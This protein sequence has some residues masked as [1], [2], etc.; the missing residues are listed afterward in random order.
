MTNQPLNPQQVTQLLNTINSTLQ[1]TLGGVNSS[2][3]GIMSNQNV[4]QMVPGQNLQQL[5]PNLNLQQLIP[6]ITTS[7]ANGRFQIAMNGNSLVDVNI[8][9]YI[10]GA[11]GQGQ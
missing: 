9:D 1:S 10:N 3:Q 4:N 7:T 6:T 11:T 5:I 2:L 8:T